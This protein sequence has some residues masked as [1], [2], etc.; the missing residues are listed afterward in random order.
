MGD[1][2]HYCGFNGFRQVPNVAGPMISTLVVHKG[3]AAAVVADVAVC[4]NYLVVLT[5]D[6]KVT[7]Y[8]LVEGKNGMATLQTPGG[9]GGHLV[10]VSATPRHLMACTREGGADSQLIFSWSVVT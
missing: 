9:S 8:G 4:W 6:G 1:S 5:D 10:Q 7:K 3:K 2:L